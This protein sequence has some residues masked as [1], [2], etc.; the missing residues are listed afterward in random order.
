MKKEN[1]QRLF[2][3]SSFIVIIGAG[4]TSK[5]VKVPV[6]ET[7]VKIDYIK[8]KKNIQKN[9]NTITY[10]FELPIDYSLKIDENGEFIGYKETLEEK[11]KVI[12]LEEYIRTKK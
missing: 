5:L 1:K 12:T 8:P 6:K 11:E 3:L 7:T 2:L 9:N 10:S 4:V